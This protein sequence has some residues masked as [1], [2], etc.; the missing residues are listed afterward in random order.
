MGAGVLGRAWHGPAW[1]LAHVSAWLAAPLAAVLSV[2]LNNL[3]AASLLAARQPSHPFSVLLGLDIGPNL[4]VTGSLSSILWWQ[5]ARLAG[6]RPSAW[7]VSRLG[8][9]A[10]PLAM[11]G[12]IAVLVATGSR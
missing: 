3:P 9:L 5:Q 2:L 12:A 7:Q 8:L 4:L 10:A 6:A 1:L 11:A